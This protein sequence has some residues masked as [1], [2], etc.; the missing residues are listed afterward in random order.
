MSSPD[1]RHRSTQRAPTLSEDLE[2]Q[3]SELRERQRQGLVPQ[4]EAE[5]E[6]CSGDGDAGDSVPPCP[7]CNGSG[8]RYVCGV[9]LA[10]YV[11]DPV[12]RAL[13]DPVEVIGDLL[14][15]K[16]WEALDEAPLAH[17]AKRLRPRFG[18]AI[19]RRVM[20]LGAR[21]SLPALDVVVEGEGEFAAALNALSFAE[22][23][24][25]GTPDETEWRAAWDVLI[26]SR[27]IGLIPHP[28]SVAE[29]VLN[30]Q[31]QLSGEPTIRTAI[32]DAL[33]PWALGETE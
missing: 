4:I 11:G 20:V 33:V 14:A 31:K 23:A 27:A 21:A 3:V 28:L 19:E 32:K 7:T 26:G 10:A 17:W 13:A 25:Y 16:T 30:C 1:T 24:V 6:W 15:L 22:D 2:R 5:C 12:A 9:E 18:E 8:K 29:V